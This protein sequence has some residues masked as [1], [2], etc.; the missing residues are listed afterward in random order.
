M[1]TKGRLTHVRSRQSLV[2]KTLGAAPQPLG[3]CQQ[4]QSSTGGID[5]S[6]AKLFVG[7]R[8]ALRRRKHICI[9]PSHETQIVPQSYGRRRRQY[10]DRR[11]S[12][13]GQ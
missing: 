9:T 5:R 12:S 13:V 1:A 3:R 4:A 10:G 6:V 11:R 8:I 7:P 2:F